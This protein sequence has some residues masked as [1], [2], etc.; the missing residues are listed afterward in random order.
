[1]KTLAI[2]LVA[3]GIAAGL[4][5]AACKPV[6]WFVWALM[7]DAR[8]E[9]EMAEFHEMATRYAAERGRAEQRAGVPEYRR[10]APH[11]PEGW[12]AWEA[13]ELKRGNAAR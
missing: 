6:A 10:F 11:P 13:A 5:Y 12:D 9:R 3:V 2:I 4:G 1:M 8:Q 7:E